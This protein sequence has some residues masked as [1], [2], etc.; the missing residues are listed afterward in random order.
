MPATRLN[1]KKIFDV[2]KY[3]SM[4]LAPALSDALAQVGTV[5]PPRHYIYVKVT[6]TLNMDAKK[7]KS[8][9][10]HNDIM[11]GPN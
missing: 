11:M 4:P 5:I 10:P 1:L 8:T 7:K 9:S 6:W 3:L 2:G